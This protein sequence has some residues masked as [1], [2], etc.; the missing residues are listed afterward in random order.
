MIQFTYNV[1]THGRPGMVFSSFMFGLLFD[2]IKSLPAL[3][4]IYCIVVRRFLHLEV[5]ENTY[6]D[7]N[8][9]KIP[10]QEN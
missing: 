8:A 4:I 1:L 2:Q 3:G 7:P 6:I 9:E 10:K 5:N